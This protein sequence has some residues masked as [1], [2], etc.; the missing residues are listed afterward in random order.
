MRAFWQQQ[1]DALL[2]DEYQD[3]NDRQRQIV[4][5]L[6]GDHGNLFIVGD[7]KQSIY[8]F[9]GAEV[10]V[11]RQ[12][13]ER[14]RAAGGAAHEL[15]VSYRP[16]AGLLQALNAFLPGVMESEAAEPWR[17]PFAPLRHRKRRPRAVGPLLTGAGAGQKDDAYRAAAACAARTPFVAG[18]R[19][20][21]TS[22]SPFFAA[23]RLHSPTR[24]R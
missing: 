21:A 19:N 4:N 6:C 10:E 15:T 24:T 7:G 23:L 1:L 14:I 9:R 20:C 3:T 2:V 22:I 8:R 17:V 5:A 12:E 11:F 18:S 13:Q 16:H